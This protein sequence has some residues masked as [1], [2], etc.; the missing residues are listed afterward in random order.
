M[1]FDK[2]MIVNILI[3]AALCG[4]GSVGV[5]LAGYPQL[6]YVL[7]A[8]FTVARYSGDVLQ[9]T[10]RLGMGI[11]DV[12]PLQLRDRANGNPPTRI[13]LRNLLRYDCDA[14]FPFAP[15]DEDVVQHDSSH[16]S[17]DILLV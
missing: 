12:F 17:R 9:R 7:F 15:D 6:V 13:L 8:G 14:R 16:V 2:R 5:V 1:K 3:Q 10:R 11:R 4:L